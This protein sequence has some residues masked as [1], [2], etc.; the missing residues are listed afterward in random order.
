MA[1]LV[2]E[3]VMDTTRPQ[4]RLKAIQNKVEGAG[5]AAFMQG[6]AS[7][8]LQDRAAERFNNGGDDA[9]GAWQPLRDSTIARREKQGYVPIKIN[10]RTG[11]LRAWVESAN[12]RIVATKSA[13]VLEWPGTPSNKTIGKKLK[14]AQQGTNSPYTPARPVVAINSGDLLTILAA[15]EAWIGVGP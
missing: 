9:S 13:A 7:Q 15:M 4:L 8:I 6:F 12:G 2:L 10:D 11:A 14:V 5:L 1:D 3:T